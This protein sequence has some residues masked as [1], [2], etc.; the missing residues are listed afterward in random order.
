M[1]HQKQQYTEFHSHEFPQKQPAQQRDQP[2]LLTMKIEK[3]PALEFVY[4]TN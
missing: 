4:Q 2:L 3:Y 1:I